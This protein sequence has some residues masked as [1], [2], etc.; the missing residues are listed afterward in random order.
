MIV[1]STI[2]AATVRVEACHGPLKFNNK[3]PNYM[4][5]SDRQDIIGMN[6]GTQ[7]TNLI[8]ISHNSK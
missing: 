2:F 7:I 1:A 3:S 6:I 8:R 5:F 4:I